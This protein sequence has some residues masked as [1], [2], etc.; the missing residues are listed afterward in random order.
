MLCGKGENKSK[1]DK[2]Q[3]EVLTKE[4]YKLLTKASH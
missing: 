2:M 3:G 1:G 4:Q